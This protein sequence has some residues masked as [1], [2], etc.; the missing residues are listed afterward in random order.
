LGLPDHDPAAVPKGACAV[1][2][3]HD[4]TP[5]LTVQLD[6]EA[7]SAIA[8]DAGTNTSH[9]AI[10]ARSLGLPAVVG[11]R[12]ATSRLTG[13]ERVVL[14]GSNGLLA[15]NPSETEVAAYVARAQ[16]EAARDAELRLLAATDAVT[17]DGVRLHLRANVDLP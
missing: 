9:I 17:T 16:R 8:T 1:L 6:R 15:V 12:D 5:S 10:L 4:L 14:D 7:I 3:T 13:T 2:V 11:L